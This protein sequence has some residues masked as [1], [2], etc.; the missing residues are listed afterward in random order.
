[1]PDWLLPTQGVKKGYYPPFSSLDTN[2]KKTKKAVKVIAVQG[3]GVKL[4]INK[5]NFCCCCCFC[6][7]IC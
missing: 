4:K 5:Q 3:G 6:I 2:A 1:M 7:C